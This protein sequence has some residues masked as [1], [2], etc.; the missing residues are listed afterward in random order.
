MAR[1]RLGILISGRGSNLQALIDACAAPSFPATVALVISNKAEAAGLD[2]ARAAAI[3]SQVISH[4]EPDF[5]AAIDAA[6]RGAGVELVCLA[7]FMRIL[8]ADFVNG[9]RDRLINI[10]PSLLP[11]F[12]GLGTHR[13]VLAAGEAVAGCTVHFVRPEIDAGP[14]ILRE[15]VPVLPGDTETSLAA[16]VLAAE[17]RLYPA[18]VRQVA[19]MLAKDGGS[20]ISLR[21]N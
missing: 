12:P 8:G 19:K 11:A 20:A 17:H 9:W 13:R 16:R 6:L 21:R 3:P 10:H 15:T 5:E 7:G 14:I 1:L 18:A 4:R 2:R